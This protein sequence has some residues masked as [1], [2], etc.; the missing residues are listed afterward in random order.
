MILCRKN[1]RNLYIIAIV[2][3]CVPGLPF[4]WITDGIESLLD[5][6]ALI[7]S[8]ALIYHLSINKIEKSYKFEPEEDSIIC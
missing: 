7:I 1:A 4:I 3:G 5:T 6:F 8:G 2:V